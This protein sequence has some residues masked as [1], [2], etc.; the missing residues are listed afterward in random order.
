[1]ADWRAFARWARTRLGS[2]AARGVL[3]RVNDAGA[4]QLIQVEALPGEVRDLVQR[5]QPYG[6]SSVPLDG[7]Y[8]VVLLCPFGDRSQAL[9]IVVDDVR[10]RPTGQSPGD[11]QVYDTHGNHVRLSAAGVEIVSAAAGTVETAGALTINAGGAVS[12]VAAGAVD[13]TAAGAVTVDGPTVNLG[14][15]GGPAVARVGDA[16]L[17]AGIPGTITAGSAKVKAA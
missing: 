8:P 10:H 15:A 6:L 16:V 14:G 5:V 11:T 9:A 1:M 13:V 12:I 4:V 17:V 3:S 2:M 7:A